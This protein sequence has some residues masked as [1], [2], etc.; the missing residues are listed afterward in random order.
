MGRER[1]HPDAARKR[2]T[3]HDFDPDRA[4]AAT[5]QTLPGASFVVNGAAQA[6]DAV[7]TAASAEMKWRNGFAVGATFEGEFSNVTRSYAGKDTVRYAWQRGSTHGSG[8]SSCIADLCMNIPWGAI[9]SDGQWTDRAGCPVN[10]SSEIVILEFKT[11]GSGKTYRMISV[12][13][14]ACTRS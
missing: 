3:A 11:R 7:L 2:R 5:F 9:N 12:L 14:G 10:I 1:R 13:I 8:D 4:I 6:R